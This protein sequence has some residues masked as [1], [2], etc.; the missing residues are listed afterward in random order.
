MSTKQDHKK[1]QHTSLVHQLEDAVLALEERGESYDDIFSMVHMIL[2]G[3]VRSGELTP[4][5]VELAKKAM[6]LRDSA[7]KGIDIVDSR[8]IAFG[9]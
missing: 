8:G 9:K 4:E 7:E 3:F 2:R 6:E 5:Y 1:K